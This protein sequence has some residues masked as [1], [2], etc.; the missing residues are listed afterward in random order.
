VCAL[1]LA[2]TACQEP[3]APHGAELTPLSIPPQL[4]LRLGL[5][6]IRAGQWE[7]G[8]AVVESGLASVDLATCDEATQALALEATALLLEAGQPEATMPW[9]ARSTAS[10]DPRWAVLRIWSLDRSD[11]SVAGWV[12]RDRQ[13][14]TLQAQQEGPVICPWVERLYRARFQRVA[15]A[16]YQLDA[17]AHAWDACQSPAMGTFIVDQLQALARDA[18]GSG[19]AGAAVSYLE[20]LAGSAWSG[21]TAPADVRESTR[22]AIARLLWPAF[23]ERR[24]A[25]FTVHRWQDARAFP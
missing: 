15:G 17:L 1:A 4:Q 20:V 10:S 25:R 13:I 24:R 9:V 3:A 19:D 7:G 23:Q 12:S 16:P 8:S 6:A 11:D 5:G 22:G 18:E 2:A 21:F 14:R